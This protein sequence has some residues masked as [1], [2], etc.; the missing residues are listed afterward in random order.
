MTKKTEA[1]II[2]PHP[3]QAVH[4]YGHE[5]AEMRLLDAWSSGKLPHA[6]LLSGPQGIGKATLAHRFARFVL[7]GQ[8]AESGLF[9]DT[10]SM[11]MDAQNP[12]FK[13]TAAGSHS[14]LLTVEPGV[15]DKGKE[16]SDIVVEDV[17]RLGEFFSLT[18]AESDWRVVI[19]DSADDMNRNAANAVLKILEEPPSYSLIILVSH[20]PG[21]LLPTIR[22]RCQGLR[23]APPDEKVFGR[24]TKEL[25]GDLDAAEIHAMEQLSGRTAGLAVELHRLGGPGIYRQLIELMAA[26]PEIN[27]AQLQSFADLV[28]A[29]DSAALW[30]ATARL[31]LILLARCAKYGALGSLPEITPGEEECFRQLNTLRPATFWVAKRSEA[32][33]WLNAADRLYLDKRQVLQGLFYAFSSGDELKVSA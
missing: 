8:S 3:R 28:S 4:L 6:L 27:T 22:S 1:E 11:Q 17:R 29:K 18:P 13:R 19:I 23:L 21:R 14:D 33:E 16:R 10:A 26:L 5:Q 15:D 20:Q 31:L 32:V 9:G 7:S 24:I 25:C 2:V 30:S 12:V